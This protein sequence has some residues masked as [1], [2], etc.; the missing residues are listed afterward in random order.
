MFKPHLHQ[1]PIN[2]SNLMIKKNHYKVDAI[3][4]KSSF[5]LINTKKNKNKNKKMT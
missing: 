3:S 1:K 2:I 5:P 4:F